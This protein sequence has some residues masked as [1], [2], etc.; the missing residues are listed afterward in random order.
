MAKGTPPIPNI[1]TQSREMAMVRY[2]YLLSL[3]P[4]FLNF[5][6][7]KGNSAVMRRAKKN[8][9]ASKN[10]PFANKLSAQR[11]LS[12]IKGR[13][14]ISRPLAG[15][16]TPMNRSDWRVSILN[17]ASR[18]ADCVPIKNARKGRYDPGKIY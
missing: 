16:G 2:R 17:L 10:H 12:A 9:K 1:N 8:E 3:N 18:M 6:A 4:K 5:R 14:E 13:V 11:N 15:V 7:I